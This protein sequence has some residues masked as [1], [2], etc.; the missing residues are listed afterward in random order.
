M[1]HCRA[2]GN[3]G[4]VIVSGMLDSDPH[5][6]GSGRL[7]PG[8]RASSGPRLRGDDGRL[9]TLIEKIRNIDRLK[10]VFHA[11]FASIPHDWYRKNELSGYEGYYA[12]IFSC[13]FTAL[14]LDVV[15]EDTTNR[16]KVDMRVN[17]DHRIF[18]FEFKVVELTPT[19]KP[20]VQLKEKRYHEKYGSGL[21]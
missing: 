1:R 3:P 16:W 10:D 7:A 20:L 15:A 18:I 4:R 9:P 17:L 21:H 19:G 12:S 13:Y 5:D 11:F 6:G 14:G 8:W 2:G